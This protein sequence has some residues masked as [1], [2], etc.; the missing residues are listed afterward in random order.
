MRG[1]IP[2]LHPCHSK[3]RAEAAPGA[4]CIDLQ[5]CSREESGPGERAS[6]GGGAAAGGDKRRPELEEPGA[7]GAEVSS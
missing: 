3:G 5:S 6:G 7:G 2:P 4:R 1:S